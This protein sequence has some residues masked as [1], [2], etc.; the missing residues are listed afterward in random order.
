MTHGF[1][2]LHQIAKRK[3]YGR[4]PGGEETA[5]PG[6]GAGKTRLP[7]RLDL[8]AGSSDSL[9]GWLEAYF[10]VEVTTAASSR[11]VQRRDLS[12]FLAFMRAEEGSDQRALWTSR[13][14]RAFLDALRSEIDP[15]GSRRFSDR[16][17]ARIAAHLK[18]FAKWIHTLRP[19]RL[20]DP[21]EKLK[22]VLTGP[23]LEIERAL[24]ESQRRKLLDAADHLP[25]LGG[26]S[27]DRRR[28]KDVEFADERPRRKGYRPWRN[29]AI[30]YCL[31]E[32]GMRRA[33]VCNLDLGE[34]DFEKHTV[35]VREKGGQ[36]HRYK[37]SKEG[38]KAIQDYL[39]EER[40]A[41]SELFPQSPALFLPPATVVNSSGHLTPR[42]VNTVWSEACRWAN[43]KHKTPH[44]ARHAMGR[45]IMNKTGNVAAVQ[46]QLGHKNA[47]YSLQ[48]AR[49]TDAELQDV[50]DER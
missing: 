24:T 16:T 39:R 4:S 36:T 9:G 28:S 30:V 42:V 50:V 38:A 23:G 13:L 14:S 12:R 17:I 22:T 34:V 45:H 47:A 10:A 37:I 19:F 8:E 6:P 33:A 43:V 48:Y 1:E 29:R 18:T 11:E 5:D 25:I 15:D 27:R 26:R 31:I 21:T 44:A 7:V 49:I 41:D 2:K 32:T 40:G 3:N 46:R 35:T 20:G